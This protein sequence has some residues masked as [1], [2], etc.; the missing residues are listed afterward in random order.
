MKTVIIDNSLCTLPIDE[1]ASPE[2]ISRYIRA[3]A[4]AGVKYVELDFRTIMKMHELPECVGY[5]FRL[6][7][8]MFAELTQAFDFNYVLV[9]INDLKDPLHIGKI[10]RA[11]V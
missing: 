11:H 3:L 6:G 7:D 4:E 2:M 5:I 1:H 10:G 9:T 8:P